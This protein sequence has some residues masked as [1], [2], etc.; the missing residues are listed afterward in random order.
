MAAVCVIEDVKPDRIPD[1]STGRKL[2]DYWGPSKRILGDMN[3]LQSLKDFDKDHIK[4]EIMVK[5]RKD[6]LPHKDFKPH[7]VAK[8]S[9]AAEELENDIVKFFR[10]SFNKLYQY[11]ANKQL[12]ESLPETDAIDFLEFIYVENVSAEA[13]ATTKMKH[14]LS[15][16][17]DMDKFIGQG[18]DG[19]AVISGARKIIAENYPRAKFVHC[20]AQVL[21]LVLAL[22]SE[23]PMIETVLEP[24][25]VS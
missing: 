4:T 12:K 6:Y 25:K 1:P 23:V 11:N 16:N 20:V 8:A 2:I 7:V 14:L 24:Y 21:N 5:I 18:F 22:S 17:L 10:H 9:S 13:L 3:F 15:Y 19:A